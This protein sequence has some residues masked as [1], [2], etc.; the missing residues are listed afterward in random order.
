MNLFEMQPRSASLSVLCWGVY[1]LP[2]WL[3][4]LFRW[5]SAFVFNRLDFSHSCVISGMKALCL[6]FSISP[7][8]SRRHRCERDVFIFLPKRWSSMTASMMCP[9]RKIQKWNFMKKKRRPRQRNPNAVSL[10]YS[11]VS[12]GRV[13]TFYSCGRKGEPWLWQLTLK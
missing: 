9:H 5:F 4:Q 13:H 1:S 11:L 12:W 2:S 7:C 3:K 8:S 10:P 6:I